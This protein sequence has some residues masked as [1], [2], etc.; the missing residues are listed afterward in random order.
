MKIRYLF[1]CVLMLGVS[2][3][4]AQSEVTLYGL[5][6]TGISYVSNA[7]G[8]SQ[9]LQQSGIMRGNRWGMKGEEDLGNGVKA[10]FAL[11]SGF[12]LE[13]GALSQGGA[14]FGRQ[15]YVGFE[16]AYG[17]LTFG[18]Q[19]DFVYDYL[20]TAYASG[21]FNTEYAFHP[22]NLDRLSGQRVDSAIKFSSKE[23]GGLR[24]GAMYAFGD[25]GPITSTSSTGR[26]VSFGATYE[27][28]PFSAGA[29][30]TEVND[31]LMT[32]AS[33]FGV[34]SLFGQTIGT[35][36]PQTGV[37]TAKS[38]QINHTREFGGGMSYTWNKLTLLGLVTN[39][40]IEVGQQSAIFASYETTASYKLQPD[41]FVSAS[42]AYE[43]FAGYRYGEIAA[44]IDKFLSKRT[45][46]YATVV[47]LRGYDGTDVAIQ[48]L[49][50]STTSSQTVFRIGMR[51]LF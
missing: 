13:N 27:H 23:F 48:S 42:Y 50:Q 6:D 21:V 14:E 24:F 15:A 8:G 38:V 26:A 9:V 16:N 40:S 10:I 22:G 43:T 3:A 44:T 41:L 35:I 36:N 25:P 28:G 31:R 30:Y 49:T 46:I 37:L 7:G 2:T 45:D 17:R 51:T 11:E 32:L 29:V 47:N 5:L 18:R 34:T 39:T 12:T 19:Y 33:Y 4:H 20:G 1:F